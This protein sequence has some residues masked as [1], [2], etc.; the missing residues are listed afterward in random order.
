MA[1]E[2]RGRCDIYHRE[3]P[4][5]KIGIINC[6]ICELFFKHDG[7]WCTCCGTR[8]RSKPRYKGKKQVCVRI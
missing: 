4:I 5:Y 7:L 1:G 2:C 8:V 3:R 6:K